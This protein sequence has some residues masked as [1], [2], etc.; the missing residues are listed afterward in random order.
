MNGD[1]EFLLKLNNSKMSKTQH[2]KFILFVS[3]TLVSF[4]G[5]GTNY[6]TI[7]VNGAIKWSTDGG[8]TDCGCEASEANRMIQYLLSIIMFFLLVTLQMMK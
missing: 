5:F 1:C 3:L 6:Q 8:I 4:F 7:D 2:F